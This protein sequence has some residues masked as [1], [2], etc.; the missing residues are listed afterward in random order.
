MPDRLKCRGAMR[1]ENQ[2]RDLVLVVWNE[3]FLKK[4]R[5]R[6]IRQ[7]LLGADTLFLC[8]RGDAGKLIARAQRRRASEKGL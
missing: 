4:S 1:V 7:L 8:L 5:E 6:D 2:A 3:R